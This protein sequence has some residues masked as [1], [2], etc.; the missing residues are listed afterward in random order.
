MGVQ[1]KVPDLSDATV[2]AGQISPGEVAGY[3]D[4]HLDLK[5]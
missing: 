3:L 5:G 1:Y 2:I 4:T